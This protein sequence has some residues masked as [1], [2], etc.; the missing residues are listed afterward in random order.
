M[1]TKILALVLFSIFL[2]FSCNQTRKQND[3]TVSRT[4][5]NPPAQDVI[6]KNSVTNSNG[7]TLDMTFNN[8]KGNAVFILKGD[9]I[10]M[11][12]DTMASGIK[13]SNG[14]YEYTEHHGE[15]R[16]SKDGVMIFEKK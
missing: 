8:T 13:Y 4:G 14:N 15:I 1:K 2:L 6:V 16:L 9:T 5:D 3:S 12:Q 7:Q 11:K 10:E